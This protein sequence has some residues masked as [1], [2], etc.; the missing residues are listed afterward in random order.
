MKKL[1]TILLL[2]SISMSIWH[3]RASGPLIIRNNQAVTYG[4]NPLIYRYDLGTLGSFSNTDAV[5][6][7]ESL[8]AEWEAVQTSMVTF[9]R[10][11]PGSLS[12]DITASNFSPILD[13]SSPL[14]YTPVVFD[15]DGS[16]VD[17]ILGTGSKNQVIGF[18]G[19]TFLY[20]S[21]Y[22]I[23]ESQ[24]LFNGR[25]ANGINTASDPEISAGAFKKAIL[26]EF[27]HAFGLDHSQINVDALNAGASQ[28]LKDSVPLMFP[29]VL[30]DLFSVMTDDASGA[31]S[32]YPNNSELRLRDHLPTSVVRLRER[33]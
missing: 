20:T 32:L 17:A 18:A 19:A 10:D 27:G 5:A 6:L 33:R 12:S 16:I 15:T 28:E 25:F 9:Q 30:T 26:H 21:P 23:A 24:A 1:L 3:V 22:E 2:I 11:N 4:T 31:S 8:F 29:Y 13:P 14:G 7:I